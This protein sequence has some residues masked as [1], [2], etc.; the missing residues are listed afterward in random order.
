MVNNEMKRTWKDADVTDLRYCHGICVEEQRKEN[1]EK[2][3]DIRF[4]GRYL[5]SGPPEHDYLALI[6]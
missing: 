3:W 2:L 6:R 5:N 1:L 4:P